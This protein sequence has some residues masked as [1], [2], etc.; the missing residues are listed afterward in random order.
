MAIWSNEGLIDKVRFLLGKDPAYDL[1]IRL[2]TNDTTP[3]INTVAGDFVECSV[4]GYARQDLAGS[5]WSVAAAGGLCQAVYPTLAWS[6]GP[7][8][9]GVSILG[10]YALNTQTG[11]SAFAERFLSPFPIPAAGGALTVSLQFLDANLT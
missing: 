11:K 10:F 4:P 8:A 7:Y 9:G 3:T 5:A 2:F 1:Q 6:F